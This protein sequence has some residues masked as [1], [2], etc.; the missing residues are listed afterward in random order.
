MLRQRPTLLI[1]SIK[2]IGVG[3]GRR[4]PEACAASMSLTSQA[5]R[6]DRDP[7]IHELIQTL[8]QRSFIV[9]SRRSDPD[10]TFR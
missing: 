6:P 7:R 5:A 8:R 3:M 2:K 9:A 10:F 1:D 4:A